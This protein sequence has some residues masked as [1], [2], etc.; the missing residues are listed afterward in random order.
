M[1]TPKGAADCGMKGR[2]IVLEE[3]ERMQASVG[4]V[5]EAPYVPLWQY[6]LDGLWWSGL[7]LGE[8]MDLS[9]EPTSDVSVVL[10]PGYRPAIKFTV[11]G[12]KGRR[13]ELTPCA[14]EF[15]LM[16]DA[17]P[18]DERTGFVFDL[19]ATRRYAGR[20][21]AA[22]V[23]PLISEIGRADGVIVNEQTGKP[24]S[25]HDYR[26]AFGTRWSKRLMPPRLMRH[27][28]IDTTLKYYEDADVEDLAE[29]LWAAYEN[30]RN[31]FINSQAETSSYCR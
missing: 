10:Q 28:K 27:K 7:R 23:G 17:I 9:W 31:T 5:V 22:T 11:M 13:A 30:S 24:V 12:H 14:P 29:D 21:A 6:Y 1:R 20:L 18:E 15:G 25:A 26:R 2:A 4:K 19:Q 8:S 3:H 16:L